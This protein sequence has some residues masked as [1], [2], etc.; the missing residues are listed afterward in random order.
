M[1]TA[2]AGIVND[3]AVALLGFVIVTPVAVQPLNVKPVLVP[4]FNVM[5]APGAWLLL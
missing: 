3:A 2:F 5:F 4:A 1:V